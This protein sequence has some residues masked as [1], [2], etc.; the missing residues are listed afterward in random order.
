[1][2][3]WSINRPRRLVFRQL[4]LVLR[5]WTPYLARNTDHKGSPFLQGAAQMES[6]MAKLVQSSPSPDHKWHLW[7]RPGAAYMVWMDVGIADGW[8]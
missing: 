6:M 3:F 2:T 5:A 8:Q 1:M 4:W 7:R